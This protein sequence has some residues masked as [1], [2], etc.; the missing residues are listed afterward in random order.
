MC[1]ALFTEID[2]S[3]D[4]VSIEEIGVLSVTMA[5]QRFVKSTHCR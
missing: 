5:G 4:N 3:I 2:V 1:K